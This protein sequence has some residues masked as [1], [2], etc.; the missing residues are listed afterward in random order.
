MVFCPLVTC[1]MA[2]VEES[3]VWISGTHRG[4]RTNRTH[5]VAF[6]VVA[7]SGVVVAEG[8]HPG[9]GLVWGLR[10][11]WTSMAMERSRERSHLERAEGHTRTRGAPGW[12]F[13]A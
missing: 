4:G 10:N 12:L 5:E 2:G 8:R 13:K 11:G 9:L 7:E 3:W 1:D 6:R